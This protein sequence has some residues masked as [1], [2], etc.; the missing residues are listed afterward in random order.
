MEVVVHGT[1][2]GYKSN[3][4]PNTTP[5]FSMGDIRNGVNSEYP[6]GK[7]A[8]SLAYRNNGCVYTKYTIVRDTLRS[9]ATGFIAFSLFLSDNKILH[10]KGEDVKSLLDKLSERYSKDYIRENNINRSETNLIQENWA[11]V[12]EILSGYTQQNKNSEE[13][14]PQS[15]PSDPAFVYYSNDSE[16]QKYFD[17]PYQEEYPPYRQVFFVESNFKDKPENPLNAL[18]HDPNADLTGKIDLENT[19]YKLREFHGQGKIGVSIEIRVNGKSRHNKDAIRKKDNVTIKYFK[20]RYFKEVF[21]EG[22]LTDPKIAQYLT[23]DESIGKIDVKKDVDLPPIEKS[24]QIEIKGYS[25]E[26]AEIICTCKSNPQLPAKV[27]IN[28]SITFSGEE[29]REKWIISAK[30]ESE[31]LYSEPIPV[32]PEIQNETIAIVLKKQKDIEI[33]TIDKEKRTTEQGYEG[34]LIA[35][36]E[37]KKPWITRKEN[38]SIVIA[39]LSVGLLFIVLIIWWSVSWSGNDKPTPL[40]PETISAYVEGDMLFAEKLDTFKI[41]WQKQEPKIKRSGDGIWGILSGKTNRQLD[42]TAFNKWKETTQSIERAIEKRKLIDSTNFA[43]LLS[44]KFSL[45]QVSLKFAIAKIDS[46]KYEEISQRLGD[47][48]KLTLTQ[49]ADSINAIVEKPVKNESSTAPIQQPSQPQ[50][51]PV[52]KPAEAPTTTATLTTPSAPTTDDNWEIIQYLKGSDLKKAT[53]QEHKKQ[54]TNSTLKKS[55]DL[56]LKFWSLDGST[57]NSYSS[58]RGKL[59]NDTNLKNSELKKIVD[60]IVDECKPGTTLIPQ[61]AIE[62]SGNEIKSLKQLENDLIKKQQ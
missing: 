60:K 52:N 22:K 21:E 24:I 48:S 23:I 43:E 7:S 10:R 37:K 38:R 9:Y 39:S 56:A 28:Q 16:L 29:L 30:K 11:F 46:T 41:E 42:S 26:G 13:G 25:I 33:I 54:T 27:A 34:A 58:Y 18:R 14:N 19:S 3:F 4:I 1:K 31:N 35:Q 47:V 20:N 8:Y 6:L 17:A 57:D 53:L 44:S 15:G 55:I 5:S 62:V 45:K 2:Q 12:N 59:K 49:I 50:P 36:Y 51:P 61:Y 32:T 40:T